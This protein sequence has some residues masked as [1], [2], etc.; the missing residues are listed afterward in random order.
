MRV[1]IDHPDGV[2]LD[3]C[4]KAT[5]LVAD[6]LEVDDPVQTEYRIEVSS[7]GV[8]RPLVKHADYQRFVNERVYIKTHKALNGIKNYTGTLLACDETAVRLHNE[9]DG[10]EHE[11]PFDMIAKATLKPVLKF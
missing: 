11:I 9:H 1:Y 5:H 7:P 4:E 3:H 6:A 8:D 10:R 2:T